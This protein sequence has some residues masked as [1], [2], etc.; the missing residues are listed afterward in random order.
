MK[1]TCIV[2]AATVCLASVAF[3]SP[4]KV[5]L[6]QNGAKVTVVELLE[7]ILL[8]LDPDVRREVRL[9]MEKN[10]GI[11]VLTES[12]EECY[13]V[14]GAVHDMFLPVLDAT[15]TIDGYR[16]LADE[17]NLPLRLY[18]MVRFEDG[19]LAS[20]GRRAGFPSGRSQRTRRSRCSG[21]RRTSRRRRCRDGVGRAGPSQILDR[22]SRGS[23]TGLT[24]LSPPVRI[25]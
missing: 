6:C 7:D 9:N 12:R 21:C 17:G 8:L 16:K 20:L 22:F 11:R 1:S 24:G 3:A 13:R 14:L 10:L 4:S 19:G 2:I 18:A 15:A 5:T 23:D 25:I